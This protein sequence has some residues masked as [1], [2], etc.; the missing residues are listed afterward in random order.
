MEEC[1]L[2]VPTLSASPQTQFVE[3]SWAFP[4]FKISNKCASPAVKGVLDCALQY[5]IKENVGQLVLLSHDVTL[6]IKSMAK[7][8]LCET[9]QQFRQS[10]ANPFSERF[11]WP[12]SSPRGLTWSCQDDLVLRE[13]FCGLPSKAGLKLLTEQFLHSH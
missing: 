10:L 1:S 2:T 13:K 7:G 8:L 4:G 5:R 11:L 12:K 3:E 9:V 6:K